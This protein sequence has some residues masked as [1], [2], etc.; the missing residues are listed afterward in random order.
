MLY[1]RIDRYTDL[2]YE[3]YNIYIYTIHYILYIGG[4]ESTQ[5][6]ERTSAAFSAAGLEKAARSVL[7][8]TCGC[9]LLRGGHPPHHNRSGGRHRASLLFRRASWFCGEKGRVMMSSRH[10]ASDG[11]CS[12]LLPL[13]CI[14]ELTNIMKLSLN[15]IITISVSIQ[16]N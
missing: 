9:C 1:Q 13:A 11:V 2:S 5:R 8:K 10:T 7:P 14:N 3:S 4:E 12:L 15:L 16:L 6:G